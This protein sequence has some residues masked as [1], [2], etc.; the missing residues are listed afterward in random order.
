M[1]VRD[2]RV[3]VDGLG[4]LKLSASQ[5]GKLTECEMKWVFTKT[6]AR[7][8]EDPA[9]RPDYFLKGDLLHD[10]RQA[11]AS[12]RDWRPLIAE[13]ATLAG[14]DPDGEWQMPAWVLHAEQIMEAW[15]RLNGPPRVE[16][17]A[18]EYPF[19][20][21]IPGTKVRVRGFL[22]GLRRLPAD[23]GVGTHDTYRIE[24]YKS[25]ARWGRETYV[26]WATDTWLYLWAAHETLPNVTG[27]DFHAIST[28]PYKPTEPKDPEDP[29]SVAKA[30]ALDD[31]KL[32]RHVPIEWDDHEAEHLLDDLRRYARRAAE[33]LAHPDRALRSRGERCAKCPFKGACLRPWDP[34]DEVRR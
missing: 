26:P 10:A 24:E 13:A 23:D 5:L 25:M 20:L 14:W 15:E 21:V 8:P 33:L 2:L 29:A 27:L 17:M 3:E 30:Q 12:G 34:W 11:W 32:F 28:Y 19:D 16:L 18:V 31:A 6:T 7:P 22:D 9:T 4:P 1:G